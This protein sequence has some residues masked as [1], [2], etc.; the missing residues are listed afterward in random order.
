MKILVLDGTAK[1][2]CVPLISMHLSQEYDVT[3]RSL[4]NEDLSVLRQ[5]YDLWEHVPDSELLSPMNDIID[6]SKDLI[7]EIQPDLLIGLKF[8]CAV[9]NSLISEGAWSK[10]ALMVDPDGVFFL[11]NNKMSSPE[12][13]V[14]FLRKN[15]KSF[16]RKSLSKLSLFKSGTTIF[17]NE[18]KS[19]ETLHVATMIKNIAS[20]LC[21]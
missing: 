9:I 10:P 1:M 6:Y 15:N 17:I 13:C 8:G 19:L 3:T 11:G 16:V 20:S 2:E 12:N 4:I 18:E 7:S 5:K 21:S 14:W